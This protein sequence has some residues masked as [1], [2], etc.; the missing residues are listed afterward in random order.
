M[1]GVLANFTTLSGNSRLGCSTDQYQTPFLH[2]LLPEDEI[3][4]MEQPKG[5][6]EQEKEEWVWMIQWELYGMKQSGRI[7]NQTI[8]KQ[9]LSWGFT[10]LSC[11]SCI[12]YRSSDSGTI[13]SAIHADDFLSIASNKEKSECCK[14]QMHKVWTISDLGIIHFIVGIAVTWDWPNHSVMLSQTA[15]INK[16]VSQFSQKN[17]SPAPLPMDPRLKLQC[18]DYKKLM[19]EELDQIS[20]LT[21]SF[22]LAA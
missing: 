4:H 21:Y 12:Y 17:T 16:I 14:D 5:F 7:W 11:E 18:T 6:K 9:M 19:H 2:G 3:K 20:K 22:S 13:I 8:N 15:L 1:H 10:C